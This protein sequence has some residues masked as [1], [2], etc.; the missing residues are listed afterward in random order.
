MSQLRV[1]A[2]AMGEKVQWLGQSLD[3][4]RLRQI[5]PAALTGVKRRPASDG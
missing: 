2:S 4:Q 1:I 3:L 5:A